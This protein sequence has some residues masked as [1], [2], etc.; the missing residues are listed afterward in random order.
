MD[1]PGVDQSRNDIPVKG[2]E[3]LGTV[4]LRVAPVQ[5]R[6]LVEVE[7]MVL[8]QNLFPDLVTFLIDSTLNVVLC[9]HKSLLDGGFVQHKAALGLWENLP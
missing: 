8:V 9:V 6:D 5:V 7:A 1:K 2:D 3:L 4:P